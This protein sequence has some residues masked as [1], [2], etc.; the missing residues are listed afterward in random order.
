[1]RKAVY[2]VLSFLV[3]ACALAQMKESLT[4]ST[5]EVPVNVVGR[6]GLPVRGL[7]SA[8]FE[9]YDEGKKRMITG[10]ES[11]DFSSPER[12]GD[13][14]AT[15]PLNPAA[16]RN[17]MLLFDLSYSNPHSLLRA[18]NAARD[19]LA[20]SVKPRDRVAVATLD[21][22]RGFR[23]L[24]AFTTDRT[25]LTQAISDP[26]KFNGSDPLQI[27]ARGPAPIPET[28]TYDASRPE[29][30]AR[31]AR[32]EQF[33]KAQK[34]LARRSAEFDDEYRSHQID[35][36]LEILAMISRTMHTI[37]GRKQ[38]VLL[39]EGFDPRLVA[40]REKFNK[41][42]QDD[43]DYI[44]KGEYWKVNTDHSFGSASSQSLLA[45]F[46]EMCRRS[47]VVLHAIDIRGLR[48]NSDPSDAGDATI[49]NGGLHLLASAGGG[50]VFKNSND[51]ASDFGR[52]M[53]QQE[54]TYILAFRAPTADPGAFHN[55]KVKIVGVPGARVSHRAGYYEAGAGSEAERTLATAEIMVND[56][57]QS[58]IHVDSLPSVFPSYGERA[59]VPVI[60]DING[61]DI[62]RLKDDAIVVADIF[63][64]AFDAH[65]SVRDSLFQRLTLDTEKLAPKLA[66]AGV[67]YF[68]TLSLPP[69]QYAIKTLVRLPELGHAGFTRQDL[70]VPQNN[71]VQMTQPLFFDDGKQWVLIR[72]TSHDAG[73][74]YPF[75]L[76]DKEFIPSAAAR[77]EAGE[78]RRFAVYVKN[79][80]N[81]AAVEVTPTASLV[82]RKGDAFIF[83]IQ[84][85]QPKPATVA[86]VLKGTPLKASVAVP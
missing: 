4:V 27:T 80:P 42:A 24:A 1:M 5:V 76:G 67:K 62:L 41:D 29:N 58:D 12:N 3:A 85:P 63:V 75:M 77:L 9:L 56:I 70:V 61:N 66:A 60:V 28:V 2:A 36:Q 83:E 30:D 43:Q 50:V 21:V 69:G 37:V 78:R 47:D 19:F 53:H 71:T 35:H 25:L 22:N 16:R 73:G 11:V 59:A 79:A 54:V 46:A 81:E 65:G 8:N 32:Q 33:S 52:L 10:F 64:Y 17:I 84:G 51:L 7:T 72:G 68:G 18:Q 48:G 38:I 44:Q 74:A 34:E 45:Q 49:S 6:D 20:A 14:G 15:T 40:G 31:T 13:D 82:D 26:K 86:V 23:L 39:S 55:L 57:P